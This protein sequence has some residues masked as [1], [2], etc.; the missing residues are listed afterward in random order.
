MWSSLDRTV[1]IMRRHAMERRHIRFAAGGNRSRQ[2]LM[3]MM[4]CAFC[5]SVSASS[6][7]KYG[8]RQHWSSG[9]HPSRRSYSVHHLKRL[10][11]PNVARSTAKPV[12]GEFH[13]GRP[14]DSFLRT[15]TNSSILPHAVAGSSHSELKG[16][17]ALGDHHPPSA[18]PNA[19]GAGRQVA[20]R[21]PAPS[22]GIDRH[23]LGR[24]P[25]IQPHGAR[26]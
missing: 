14:S 6:S 5:V 21:G 10:G 4:L 9:Y 7:A 20:H 22:P 11:P 24:N 18:S 25:V 17:N 16:T 12:R 1:F 26:R 15:E 2:G 3:L 8:M 13:R 23:S 19:I